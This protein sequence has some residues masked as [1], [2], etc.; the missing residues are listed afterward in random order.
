MTLAW[1]L[2]QVPDD[3]NKFAMQSFKLF[4]SVFKLLIKV[5]HFK[6][7]IY[8]PPSEKIWSEPQGK[9]AVM[10]HEVAYASLDPVLLLS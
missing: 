9:Q 7:M 10:K 8:Q 2:T 5:I 1:E 4:F 3:N 6:N